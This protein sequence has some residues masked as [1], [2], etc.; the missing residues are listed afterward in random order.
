VIA[1][2]KP[3]LAR[4]EIN[5]L[6]ISS[7]PTPL[8]PKL[9]GDIFGC[10][11]MIAGIGILNL[12]LM[13]VYERT[14]EI[15]VLGAMGLKPRQISLLF[16]LEGAMIGLVGASAGIVLGL[17]FNGLLRAVGLDFTAFSSV[18]E[19]SALITDKVYPS[20][21][22]E[23]LLEHAL[24]VAVIAALAAVIPA[25][26]AAQREPLKPC[27]TYVC[28]PMIRFGFRNLVATAGAPSFLPWQWEWRWRCCCS[29]LL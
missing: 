20:W 22:V 2:I 17:V 18:T 5:R 24:T 1:D 16:I 23:K 14:R 26:E 29:C 7:E 12:L 3:G 15:G 13:A 28:V 10:I 8:P 21:G 9:R 6:K 27:N 19:Y 11:V 4:Y 25:R